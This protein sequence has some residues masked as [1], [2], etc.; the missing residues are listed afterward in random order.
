[1]AKFLLIIFV[2]M[3]WAVEGVLIPFYHYPSLSDEEVAKL[4]QLRKSYP[5]VKIIAIINPNNGNISGS[6]PNFAKAIR[7]L[8]GSGIVTLGYV[9]SSYGKRDMNETLKAVENW[10]RYYKR[11][12]IS[13]IFLDEVDGSQKEYYDQIAKKVREDFT[14]LALNPGVE[15]DEDIFRLADIV[16][17]HE[18][19]NIQPCRYRAKSALLLHEQSD[20][21]ESHKKLYECFDYIYITEQKTPHPWG[22]ISSHIEKLLQMARQTHR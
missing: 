12:G 13:G 10:K 9:Y 2:T 15:V 14:L 18:H 16:V 1:M 6:Q 21:N 22:K 17:T 20:L 7:D 19:S 4:L 3:A 5:D 11:F 8:N